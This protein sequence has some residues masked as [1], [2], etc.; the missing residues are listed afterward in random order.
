MD[1]ELISKKELLER[2]DISYGQLYRWKRK[3]LIPEDWFIRKS[4]YTGQETFFPRAKVLSRIEKIKSLK[5]DVSLDDIA[6]V[7]SPAQGAAAL[8]RD[9]LTANGLVTS[10]VLDIYIRDRGDM[11][12]FDFG[13]IRMIY[14]FN[15]LLVSGSV[16]LDEGRL[17]LDLLRTGLLRFDSASFDAVLARKLGSF[18]CFAVPAGCEVCLDKDMRLIKRISMPVVTEELKLKMF[19]EENR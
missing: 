18:C 9:E 17:V 1:E 4:A 8:S 7:F 3:G 16:S 12:R 13:E 14:I 5:E 11:P 6:D 2:A 15:N 19:E 10:D